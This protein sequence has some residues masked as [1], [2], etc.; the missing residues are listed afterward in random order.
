MSG[1]ATSEAVETYSL[2]EVPPVLEVVTGRPAAGFVHGS[3]RSHAR[4]P[5]PYVGS[6]NL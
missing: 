2:A 4:P 1:I 5:H 3:A 6:T